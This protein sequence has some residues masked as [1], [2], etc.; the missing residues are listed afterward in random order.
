MA[1]AAS[2]TSIPAPLSG[3]SVPRLASAHV[4]SLA[5]Q[6]SDYRRDVLDDL[7][8]SILASEAEF[9]EDK[10]RLAQLIERIE[11]LVSQRELLQEEMR[12][13]EHII[14]GLSVRR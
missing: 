11:A 4:P 1:E 3:S 5:Q 14:A 9:N 10:Q 8:A 6:V 2:M 13:V 12:R 7:E